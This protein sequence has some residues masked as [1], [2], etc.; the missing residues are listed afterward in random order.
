ML[1]AERIPNLKK[2]SVSLRKALK[3]AEKFNNIVPAFSVHLIVG[4]MI[5]M[6]LGATVTKTPSCKFDRLFKLIYF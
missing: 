4:M 5:V 6:T 2:F 3:R 1:K